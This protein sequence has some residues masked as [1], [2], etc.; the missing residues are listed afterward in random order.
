MIRK[1][2][3]AMM[4]MMVMMMMMMMMIAAGKRKYHPELASKWELY[5]QEEFG[6]AFI[7]EERKSRKI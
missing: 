2:R 5:F 6:T 4:M 1:V 7:I 3:N